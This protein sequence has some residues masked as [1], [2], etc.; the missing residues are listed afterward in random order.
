[1]FSGF[2]LDYEQSED[3]EIQVGLRKGNIVNIR[4]N[5]SSK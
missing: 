3:P 5:P 1:M 2:L 4:S